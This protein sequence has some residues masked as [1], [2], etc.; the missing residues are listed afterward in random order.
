MSL[1]NEQQKVVSELRGTN[2]LISELINTKAALEQAQRERDEANRL[3]KSLSSQ[4]DDYEGRLCGAIK[5]LENERDDL[6]A[7]LLAS[8][9]GGAEMRKALKLAKEVTSHGFLPNPHTGKFNQTHFDVHSIIDK[10]L[11]TTFGQS[12][13]AERERLRELLAYVRENVTVEIAAHGDCSCDIPA[14][15]TP[16][17]YCASI[18]FNERTDKQGTALQPQ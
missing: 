16:C 2:A 7:K 5:E 9:A 14:G 15:D 18:H 13:L 3:A 4:C 10:A 8:E 12:F 17:V 1:N 11:S 6:A